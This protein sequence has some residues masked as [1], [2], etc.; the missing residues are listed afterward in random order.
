MVKVRDVFVSDSLPKIK[1]CV[2]PF[3]VAHYEGSGW[4]R[5]SLFQ[6]I[7]HFIY[8]SKRIFEENLR[9]PGIHGA[10]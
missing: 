6:G 5:V 4:L 10:L 9:L 7:L 3:D 2:L 1:Q 8:Y